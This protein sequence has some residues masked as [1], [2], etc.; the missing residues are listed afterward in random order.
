MFDARVMVAG[1]LNLLR[2]IA[3]ML[4]FMFGALAAGMAQAATPAA[5]SS[6]GNQASAT[7]T[8]ASAIS[9][10]ST[11]NTVNT[12]VQQVASFTLTSAHSVSAA[13]GAP[14]A[15]SH[16]ITNTGNGSDTF[17]LDISATGGSVP[18]DL[19]SATFYIDA[20]CNGIAD[21]GTAITSLGPIAAGSSSCFIA[22]STVS[23][24]A[25]NNDTASFTV[26]AAT[27]LAGSSFAPQTNVDSVTVTAN[28]VIT[29]LKSISVPS[30]A[31]GT[32]V[33]YTLTY[34][35]SGNNTATH[36]VLADVIPAGMTYVAGS[37]RWSV[38]GATAL[39][40]AT[41]G[42]PAGIAYDFNVTTANTVTANI[43]SVLSGQSGTLTFQATVNAGV[44]PGTINNTGDYCYYDGATQQP[45]SSNGTSGAG[46]TNC[47]TT[48]T[49]TGTVPFTVLQSAAVVVDD[50]PSSTD[51]DASLNDVVHQAAATQGST[52]SFDVVVHNNG[53]GTDTFNITLPGPNTFPSGTSFALY[54]T[55]GAV[56]LT[57]SGVDGVDTGPIAAGGSYHVV[58]KAT[59][60]GSA[61]G[62]GAYD[63]V[64]KATSVA[65]PGT[66]DTTTI[67]LG[68][69]TPN[70]I[71]LTNDKAVATAVAGDGLGPD[72]GN[73]KRTVSV[74]PGSTATF[75]LFV[76]NTSGVADNFDLST[77]TSLPSGWTVTFLAATGGVGSECSTT[78]ASLTNT[79]TI[80]AG[81]NKVVCAVVTTTAGSAAG[82]TDVVFKALSPISTAS[83][84]IKDTVT[85]NTLRSLTLTPVNSGQIFAGGSK[86]YT[87]VLKNTGTVTETSIGLATALTG[88]TA[89][90]SAVIYEDTDSSGALNAGDLVISSASLA[91]GAS[92]TLFVKVQAPGSAAAGDIDVS[93][94]TATATACSGGTCSGSPPAAPVVNTT[95][96][97][98][99]I[100]G[101]VALTKEQVLDADCD[102]NGGAGFLPGDYSN[103][104]I[105]TGAIPG[106]CVRYR[107]TAQN[108]G[109]ADVTSLVISDATPSNTRYNCQGSGAGSA[110]PAAGDAAVDM[111]SITLSP[112]H[113]STGTVE[114]TVGTLTP[115]A[116]AVLTF[117]IQINP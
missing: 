62:G 31:P 29:V 90:W 63:N 10:T 28:A 80:T 21:N 78:G 67:E 15:F 92:K 107:I 96:T 93:T 5:N 24:G 58:V 75:T 68:T 81:S 30:G 72:D 26:R 33:T 114:A 16:Q 42:D 111:G 91:P 112:S 113:C 84:T 83:D 117:S 116:S 23:G 101:Q 106:A 54:Q 94:L 44:V 76:N 109:A 40:D 41:G 60:P 105:T 19:S 59:L 108:L 74:N 22:A 25:A 104:N 77:T 65:D 103:G 9:R 36:V 98:T 57:D 69:I 97:S 37:G 99:V 8:D 12:I 11:S 48:G 88:V 85:V 64:V 56:P 35:N 110:G 115:G 38:S 51:D 7:Y 27:T 53:N 3:V 13:P 82:D 89:S 73:S 20:N 70:T 6:I 43:D 49:P 100:A 52:V 55:G 47:S 2:S 14:L 86:V 95:D 66:S 4:L 79:G 102:N 1:G 39:D 18:G 61:L 32:T 46:A 71:D 34:T 87:H 50:D 45:A 17:N